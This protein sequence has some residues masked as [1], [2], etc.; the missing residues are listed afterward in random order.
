ML[1]MG[2]V[3]YQAR[4]NLQGFQPLA[5]FLKG[6]DLR[7][8]SV[9]ATQ[10]FRNEFVVPPESVNLNTDHEASPTAFFARES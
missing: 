5:K 9:L 10:C 1:S 2:F 6:D 7:E 3:W 8:L 4:H